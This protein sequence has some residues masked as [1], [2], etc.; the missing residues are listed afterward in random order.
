MNSA[1]YQELINPSQF[2]LI[3]ALTLIA[4]IAISIIAILITLITRSNQKENPSFSLK[5][6]EEGKGK[7]F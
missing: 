7:G 2:N 5:K 3:A 6:K 4:L 1:L